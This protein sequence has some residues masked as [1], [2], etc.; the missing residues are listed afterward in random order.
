MGLLSSD[1]QEDVEEVEARVKE[2]RQMIEEKYAQEVIDKY[3]IA[4]LVRI[5]RKKRTLP[6]RYRGIFHIQLWAYCFQTQPWRSR[7]RR[8]R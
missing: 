2:S 6:P 3:V 4:P 5:T 8:S 7:P 1:L